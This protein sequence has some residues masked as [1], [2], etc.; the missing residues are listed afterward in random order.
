MK[1][2]KTSAVILL[3]KTETEGKYLFGAYNDKGDAVGFLSLPEDHGVFIKLL[4]GQQTIMGAN[5]LK[6]TPDDFPDGGRVCVTHHPGNVKAPALAAASIGEAIHL[7]KER[8]QK[9]GKEKV[10]VIGGANLIRQC[11]EENVLDEMELTLVYDHKE[12]V[13]HPVYLEFDFKNWE[14]IGDSGM[15]TSAVSEPK[16][17]EYRFLTLRQTD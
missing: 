17:L 11:L 9:A 10:Y 16:G 13:R 6:A 5:T 12:D 4:I 15:L 7:A 8:A 3:S 14:I 2:I 1:N